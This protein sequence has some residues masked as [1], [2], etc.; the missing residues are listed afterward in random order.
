MSNQINE[1]AALLP[2]SIQRTFQYRSVPMIEADI[3]Y[4]Q[5]R[6]RRP[7]EI[8]ARINS[9]YKFVAMNLLRYTATKLFNEAVAQYRYS[10]QQ[11]YPF[12]MYGTGLD[13][14]A[15]LNEGCRLSTYSDRYE[16]TGG[17]HPLTTR[18]SVTWNLENGRIVKLPE[19]FGGASSP[20]PKILEAVLAQADENYA[21]E[22]VYFDNYRELI[23]E[24]LSLHN[25]YLTP[26]AVVIYFQQY[27]IAPYA[28][29]M[30]E[31]AL[32]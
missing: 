4:P 12:N 21:K 31:F 9:H 25:F 1:Q 8:E 7:R 10:Q 30:P 14:T 32:S 6:L 24:H 19:L 22:P 20:K 28:A 18:T 17:A 16:Y 23:A 27:E 13:Y 11:G 26:Q 5:V 29:G 15:A 3:T 2:Q